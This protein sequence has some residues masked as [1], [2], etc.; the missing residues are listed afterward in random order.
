MVCGW[1]NDAVSQLLDQFDT[2]ILFRFSFVA[3]QD[4]TAPIF[5]IHQSLCGNYHKV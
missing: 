1:L 2:A 3:K 4:L 5:G